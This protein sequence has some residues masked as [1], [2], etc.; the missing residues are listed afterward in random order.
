M[1]FLLVYGRSVDM[2]NQL[3][4]E[5]AQLRAEIA[6]YRKRLTEIKEAII[7][8]GRKVEIKTAVDLALTKRF[9]GPL[10]SYIEG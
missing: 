10:K 8:G 7:F 1:G 3:Q 4:S 9:D 2:N 6:G 5:V